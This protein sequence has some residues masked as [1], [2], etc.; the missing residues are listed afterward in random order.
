MIVVVITL[1]VIH[2]GRPHKGEGVVKSGRLR[3]EIEGKC[4]RPQNLK[5]C[6]ITED[7]LK[8]CLIIDDNLQ[9]TV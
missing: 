1:G 8:K 7:S 9:I 3:G 4:G 6:Q 2:Q 5:N